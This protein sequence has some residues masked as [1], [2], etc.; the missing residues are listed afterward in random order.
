MEYR[1]TAITLG[2]CDIGE[3]DR[4]YTFYTRE[5]GKIRA[6]A[7][8]VRKPNARLAAQLEN[9]H[10]S[11]I[12]V[13][14]SRGVGNIKSVGVEEER[15]VLH[16]SFD[17]MAEAFIVSE[18][19]GKRIEWEERDE[20]LF[21]KLEEYLNVLKGLVIAGK[22]EKVGLLSAVFIFQ[23]LAHL[24]HALELGQCVVSG[25]KLTPGDHFVSVERGGIVDP[26]SI[27]LSR[28]FDLQKLSME[29]IKL[30]R[31]AL[32][33]PLLSIMKVSIGDEHIRAFL[34]FLKGYQDRVFR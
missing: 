28:F 14:R 4:L 30:M 21:D 23:V 13:M 32:T 9:F 6:V 15:S 26:A 12:I 5:S 3:A 31:L 18:F 22:T 24:G 20:I 17:A 34:I 7:R 11:Q 29:N 10:R 27:G 25:G 16:T 33:H 2:K 19:F 1:Y 8:G